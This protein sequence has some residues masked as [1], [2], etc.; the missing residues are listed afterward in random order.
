MSVSSLGA[1]SGAYSYL[2]SLLPPQS[3]DGS[4]GA[5]PA[6]PIAQ[7]LQAFYPNGATGQSGA[8]ADSANGATA[9]A[10]TSSPT[11]AVVNPQFSPD[12]MTAMMSVQEQYS[13]ANPFVAAH[14]QALF[15]QLD[16]N[17][18]GQVSKSELESVFGSNADMSK[19]DG[20]FNALDGNGDGSVSQDELTS[21]VQAS[22]AHHHGH[23]HHFDSG[24]GGDGGIAQALM[25][26]G[27][28][29]A[30]ADTTTSA[31]G[32][33]TTTIS[34]AD[35]SKVSLTSPP[36]SNG[37]GSSDTSSSGTNDANLLEQ[38]IRLQAQSLALSASQSLATS[39]TLTSL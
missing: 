39:Q 20:L 2:Q 37:S 6:D 27:T 14:A 15:S 12:T 31:D 17:G 1:S 18:D 11:S 9:G 16:A 26:S 38:L 32:S 7:L 19:V 30:T 28:Q 36:A 33:S 8:A 4:Q 29:G 34:Y 23:H 35:G 10:G 25:T 5:R 21:A 22:H 24:Q 13:G 3:A